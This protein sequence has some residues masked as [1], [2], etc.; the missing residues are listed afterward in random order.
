MVAIRGLTVLSIYI[1]IAE[2]FLLTYVLSHIGDGNVFA[3]DCND[4]QCDKI[5][6]LKVEKTAHDQKVVGLNPIFYICPA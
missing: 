6:N 4:K 1:S 5:H 2:N 3:L